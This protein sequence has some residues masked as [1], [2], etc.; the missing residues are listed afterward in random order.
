LRNTAKCRGEWRLEQGSWRIARWE[1]RRDSKSVSVPRGGA[2]PRLRPEASTVQLVRAYFR[3]IVDG[4][5]DHLEKFF[6]PDCIVHR[7]ELPAPIRGIADLTRF[8]RG[9]RELVETQH[10]IVD[11]IIADGAHAVARVRHQAVF[12]GTL[13]TPLGKWDVRGKRVE[14]TAIAWFD[15]SDG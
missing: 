7:C 13:L 1:I 6:L 12:G 10:T 9:A 4:R 11:D 2:E 3:E 5:G 8:F 15:F 14:W